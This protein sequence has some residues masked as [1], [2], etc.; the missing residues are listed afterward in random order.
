MQSATLLSTTMTGHSNTSLL[1]QCSRVKAT[2][3]MIKPTFA[4]CGW[5]PSLFFYNPVTQITLWPN[6]W[7][8]TS[9]IPCT[10]CITEHESPTLPWH[11]MIHQKVMWGRCV[12]KTLL[13]TN[14][15]IQLG[16]FIF[17]SKVTCLIIGRAMPNWRDTIQPI[18]D[19]FL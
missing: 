15:V 19:T 4:V 6:I 16:A 5:V 13:F 18:T 10:W 2:S 9:S 14:E 12:S 11:C 1:R 7:P 17:L 8:W 3:T